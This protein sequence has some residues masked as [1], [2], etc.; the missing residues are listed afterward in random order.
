M[1]NLL[2]ILFSSNVYMFDIPLPT[3]LRLFFWSCLKPISVFSQV[4][5][6]IYKLKDRSACFILDTLAQQT[7]LTAESRYGLSFAFK[8][9]H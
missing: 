2:A 8:L 3:E 1:I 7:S 5:S 9:I 4:V 6:V